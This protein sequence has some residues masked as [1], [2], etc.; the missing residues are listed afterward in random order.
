MRPKPRLPEWASRRVGTGYGS[1]RH[2]KK[3]NGAVF[4]APP[5]RES[6]EEENDSFEVLQGETR[7]PPPMFK[8]MSPICRTRGANFGRKAGYGAA[9]LSWSPYGL[10]ALGGVRLGKGRVVGR[11]DDFGS[12][13]D[14]KHRE[15]FFRVRD[16]SQKVA[17]RAPM[18]PPT[19]SAAQSR[20]SGVRPGM[21]RW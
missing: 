21:S 1:Y 3:K 2:G 13:A 19:R 16:R 4:T 7:P 8:K 17:R 5:L 14:A 11:F 10:R 6:L 18:K 9:S 20:G 15:A 12:P